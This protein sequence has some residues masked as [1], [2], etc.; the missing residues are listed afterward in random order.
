MIVSLLAN[1]HTCISTTMLP[2][3]TTSM[4]HT[5]HRHTIGLVGKDREILSTPAVTHYV[6]PTAAP[7]HTTRTVQGSRMARATME[8]ANTHTTSC[9]LC[10]GISC[11]YIAGTGQWILVGNSNGKLWHLLVH[12]RLHYGSCNR[13]DISIIKYRT[14]YV[15]MS[16][17]LSKRQDFLIFSCHYCHVTLPLP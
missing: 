8:V 5:S 12:T 4:L 15:V 14:I 7:H 6:P 9:H 16:F 17:G 11:G 2:T 1:S 10:M 13:T 3:A